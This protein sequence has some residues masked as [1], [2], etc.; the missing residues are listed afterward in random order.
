MNEIS[1]PR[2]SRC[3]LVTRTRLSTRHGRSR[4]NLILSWNCVV[5]GRDVSSLGTCVYCLKTTKDRRIKPIHCPWIRAFRKERPAW[6][7]FSHDHL[8]QTSWAVF[9]ITGATSIAIQAIRW[10]GIWCLSVVTLSANFTDK[11]WWASKS[12][13]AETAQWIPDLRTYIDSYG[14]RQQQVLRTSG[15]RLDDLPFLCR[16]TDW[17]AGADWIP[18]SLIP[19]K[20]SVLT[21]PLEEL[22]DAQPERD[23]NIGA[24]L[25]RQPPLVFHCI[26]PPTAYHSSIGTHSQLYPLSR[27]DLL[28]CLVGA[29]DF[30]R[31]KSRCRTC[32]ALLWITGYRSGF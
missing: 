14:A 3:R 13:A 15:R 29:L 17:S 11:A 5:A 23:T 22:R 21:T 4:E 20:E 24:Q 10:V 1:L 9:T 18:L 6:L 28:H 8:I 2:Y 19:F 25:L 26:P 31:Y 12:L 32:S 30:H 7:N 16:L 27:Q